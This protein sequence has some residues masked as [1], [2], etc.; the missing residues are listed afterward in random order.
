MV[1]SGAFLLGTIKSTNDETNYFVGSWGMENKHIVLPSLYY[2]KRISENSLYIENLHGSFH[3]LKTMWLWEL[4]SPMKK[5]WW[6][7]EFSNN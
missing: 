4:K 6:D 2:L 5:I 1:I 3:S 7:S